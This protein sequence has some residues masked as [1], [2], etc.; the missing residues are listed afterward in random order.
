MK[1]I[2]HRGNLYGPDPETENTQNQ[3]QKCLDMGFDVELDLWY[4]KKTGGLM[5]GHDGPNMPTDVTWIW[6]KSPMLWMHWKETDG[7]M[8]AIYGLS[9]CLEPLFANHF[10]HEKEP[11]ARTTSGAYWLYPGTPITDEMRSAPAIVACLP[12]LAPDWD[13]THATH[14]CTDY[15]VKYAEKYK[16]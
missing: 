8:W 9:V 2:A 7:I 15:P 13:L 4:I 14:I 11:F 10:M 12:E 3:A 5:L 6:A 16:P 1:I